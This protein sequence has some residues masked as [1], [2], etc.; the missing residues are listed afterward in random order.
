MITYKIHLLRCAGTEQRQRGFYVGQ[1]DFPICETG[2]D[3]LIEFSQRFEYPQVDMVLTSPLLRCTQTADILYPDVYTEQMS[4][5]RDLCLGEFEGKTPDR[6]A[7]N[8]A[9]EAWLK[10][11][12]ENTPPGGEGLQDFALRVT[13]ALESIF[14]R[15]MQESIAN[16]A[17]ITHAGVIMTLLASAGIPRLAPQEW[18]SENGCG[19]TLLMSAQMWMR[20]RCGEVFERIPK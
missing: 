8:P 5:L 3:A 9:F 6:L 10:N 4:E 17:V 15:M 2:R 13:G 12:L 11:S 1:Q 20:S 16:I 7:D 19:F 18:L 14:T